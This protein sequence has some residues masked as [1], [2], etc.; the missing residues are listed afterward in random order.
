VRAIVIYADDDIDEKCE[1]RRLVTMND[2]YLSLSLS[3]AFHVHGNRE[4]IVSVLVLACDN[5]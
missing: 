2:Y 3:L 4:R 1:D 5:S